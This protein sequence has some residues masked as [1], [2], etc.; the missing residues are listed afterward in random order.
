MLR[1]RTCPGNARVPRVVIV[2]PSEVEGSRCITA[3][4]IAGFFRLRFATLRMT[5]VSYQFR[6]RFGR[7]VLLLTLALRVQHLVRKPPRPFQSPY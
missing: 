1:R 7:F 3:G 2:I 6:V 5:R 4:V